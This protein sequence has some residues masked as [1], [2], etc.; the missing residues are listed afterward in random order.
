MAEL[1]E[2]FCICS[3]FW[4]LQE[5]VREALKAKQLKLKGFLK[6]YNPEKYSSNVL[7]SNKAEW[8]KKVNACHEDIM[9]YAVVASTAAGVTNDQEAEIERITDKVGDDLSKFYE[10][11]EAKCAVST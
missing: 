2:T 1:L 4:R 5:G 6:V 7:C 10:D 9:D 3:R 11:F 8:F